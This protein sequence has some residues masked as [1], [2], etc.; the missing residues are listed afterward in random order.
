[1]HAVDCS[2][3]KII[4]NAIRIQIAK[5]PIAT[6]RRL[7]YHSALVSCCSGTAYGLADLRVDSWSITK[8]KKLSS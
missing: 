4:D 6:A 3:I 5:H 2:T 1:M 7:T 8:E